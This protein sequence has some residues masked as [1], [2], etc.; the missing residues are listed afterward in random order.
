M[1]APRSVTLTDSKLL[2]M[3][4]NSMFTN[5]FPFLREAMEASK[6]RPAVTVPAG[7]TPCRRRR[8]L[9]EA[10]RGNVDYDGTRRRIKSMGVDQL[11]RLKQLLQATEVRLT[12]MDGNRRITWKF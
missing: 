8:L 2:A 7:C 9:R 11:R 3:M 6:A 4:K 5:E 12:Y 1:P 10:A